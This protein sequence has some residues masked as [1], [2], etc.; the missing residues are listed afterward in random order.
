MPTVEEFINGQA[1]KFEEELC[2]LLRIPSISTDPA[3][4]GEMPR[5]AGWVAQRFGSLGFAAE[6]VET[7]GH[8]LVYAESPKIGQAPTAL[9]Y[10][11]YDV[12]PVE[13]L[14]LWDSPPFEPTRRD[15]CLY[16]R[17]ASDDKG[18]F[19][20]H[21]FSARAW[22]ASEGKLPLNLKYLIEGE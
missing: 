3:Y 13:P 2:E 19:L 1:D 7:P 14:N 10:G 15:G 12:Q 22:I 5:A 9:V 11:H 18:Q 8:P 6:V 4:R 21:L 20:T 17:G 16:A